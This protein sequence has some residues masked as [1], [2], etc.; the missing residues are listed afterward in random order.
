MAAAESTQPVTDVLDNMVENTDGEKVSLK[1]LL[2]ALDSRSYGPLLLLVGVIATAPIIG[3]IPGMSILTGTLVIVLCGQM[4]F[5]RSHPWLPK[6]LLN[7][8]F[9][10]EK[11][12]NAV[13]KT[14]PWTKWAEKGVRKR[15][16][17]LAE[18]PALIGVAAVCI[19]LGLTFYPLAVVP[20]AVFAPGIAICI[21]AVGIT[22]RDGL[23]VLLGY[24]SS[25]VSA[26]VLY[27]MWPF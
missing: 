13:E 27:Q 17:V 4:L 24:I 7:F 6:K 1:D 2:D 9:D 18:G 10:R 22:A 25:A 15:L 16:V 19:L 14:K 3:G 12:D 11:L 20:F 8:E 26:V 5:L 21:F 23:L